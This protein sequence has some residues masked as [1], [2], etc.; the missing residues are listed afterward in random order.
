VFRWVVSL[1]WHLEP[2]LDKTSEDEVTFVAVG[3]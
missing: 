3:P 1:D 2:D